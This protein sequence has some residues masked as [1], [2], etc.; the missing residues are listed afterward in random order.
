MGVLPLLNVSNLSLKQQQILFEARSISMCNSPVVPRLLATY[1]EGGTDRHAVERIK[2]RIRGLKAKGAWPYNDDGMPGF[3]YLTYKL[4]YDDEPAVS[5]VKPTLDPGEPLVV[6]KPQLNVH[7]IYCRDT[8]KQAEK[9]FVEDLMETFWMLPETS[10][11]RLWPS[12]SNLVSKVIE[13]HN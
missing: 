4:V 7:N 2:S 12:V 10:Q 11:N 1:I 6:E 13:P 3:R 9:D 8:V 5:L